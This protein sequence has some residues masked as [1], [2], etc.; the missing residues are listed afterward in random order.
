MS[1]PIASEPGGLSALLDWG[2]ANL[3]AG[4]TV[5][6]LATRGAMSARTL[7]RR[8]RAAPSRFVIARRCAVDDNLPL[9]RSND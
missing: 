1:T 8:F 9:E 4:V 5:D 2:R 6:E 3:A 7:T